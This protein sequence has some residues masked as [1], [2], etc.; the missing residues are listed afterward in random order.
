M[1]SVANTSR[2]SSFVGKAV[3]SGTKVS[4]STNPQL[5]LQSTKDKFKL[6]EKAAAL[7]GI[8]AGSYVVLLDVNRG[9]VE[10]T[11]NADRYFITKGYTSSNAQAGAK[12][13]KKLDFSYSGI[14]AAMLMNKPEVTECKTDDLLALGLGTISDKSE[15]F[16]SNKKV[17]MDVRPFEV[18]GEDGVVNEFEVA[19]GVTQ[20]IY[21]L[22][23]LNFVDHDIK[24]NDEDEDTSADK[25]KD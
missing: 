6:N 23:N 22:T 24:V 19:P 5:I 9:A 17:V 1:K 20:K 10:T 25:D 3:K 4:G 8:D 7:M 13:G 2:F 11:S 12:I 14:W 15:N 16:I 18:E 21:I